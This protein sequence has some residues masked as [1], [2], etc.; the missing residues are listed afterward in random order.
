ML[1]NV[2]LI[3]KNMYSVVYQ[4]HNIIILFLYSYHNLVSVLIFSS[5]TRRL[6]LN[7]LNYNHIIIIVS[8][9]ELYFSTNY[10]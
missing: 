4:R 3:K 1:I 10:F 6:N 8:N 5:V 7:I 9:N 2:M